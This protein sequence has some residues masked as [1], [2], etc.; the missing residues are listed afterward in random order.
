VDDT[1]TVSDEALLDAATRGDG[2][3]F[4]QLYDRH[5]DRVFRHLLRLSETVADAEDLVGLVFVE[6]WRKRNMIRVV[7]ADVLPWLLV[8]ASNLARNYTRARRRYRSFLARVPYPVDEPD[9]ADA[10]AERLDRRNRD[11]AL[12]SAFDRLSNSDR[13][14]LTLCVLEELS[15]GDAAAALGVPVGTVKS[16]LARAKARLA[17]SLAGDLSIE[18]L[19]S[20][21]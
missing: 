13:E 2:Q 15:T 10:V 16:R 18:A 12:R 5:R 1:E 21:L 4:G 17:A 11:R 3:A 9:H 19:R 6:A 20:T 8:T 7:K 14:V